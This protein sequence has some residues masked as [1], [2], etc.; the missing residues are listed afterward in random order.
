MSMAC[1]AAECAKASSHVKGL[2][3]FIVLPPQLHGLER[4]SL[5]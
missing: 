5:I 3:G 4:I 1:L 2:T